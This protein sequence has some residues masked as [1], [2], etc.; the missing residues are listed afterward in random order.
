MTK[1]LKEVCQLAS[2]KLIQSLSSSLNVETS[3][4]LFSVIR[5]SRHKPQGRPEHLSC[6][7][8]CGKVM[9]PHTVYK[10]LKL[11]FWRYSWESEY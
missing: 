5:N 2:S 8:I 3:R 1:N 10:N 7:M 9:Q 4:F 6:D 11:L